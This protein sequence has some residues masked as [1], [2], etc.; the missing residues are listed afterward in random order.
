MGFG[1]PPPYQTSRFRS[2]GGRTQAVNGSAI[3]G[4]AE[5]A[6]SARQ[7]KLSRKTIKKGV[8]KTRK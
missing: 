6:P 5:C 4:A 8:R 2:Q 1:D 7:R 3:A